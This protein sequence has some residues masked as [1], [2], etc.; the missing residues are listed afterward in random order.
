M[1]PIRSPFDTY[2]AGIWV[3]RKNAGL[4][5]GYLGL[6]AAVEILFTVTGLDAAI[7]GLGLTAIGVYTLVYLVALFLVSATLV[8]PLHASFLSD[9]RIT[10]LAAIESFGR[11]A[12][13]GW[14]LFVIGFLGL[15]PA[16]ALLVAIT[17]TGLF[18]WLPTGG[19]SGIAS[20]SGVNLYM[21]AL[22]LIYGGSSGL[23]VILF[24]P[25]IPDIV[26]GN[27]Q[28]PGP[29]SFQIGSS[30]FGRM[31]QNLMVGPGLVLVI[32]YSLWWGMVSGPEGSLPQT[33]VLGVR[34]AGLCVAAF[35]S[36]MTAA[37]LSDGY[38]RFEA[39]R[40]RR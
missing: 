11:L 13:I 21:A 3:V 24:G 2:R 35:A 37:V 20:G 26:T 22:I 36:A 30:Q 14:R 28:R 25:L 38:R 15:V 5:A 8:Y 40:A 17:A 12:R 34:L 6:M 18:A 1:L 29:S 10:G 23:S 7:L 33:V 39:E 27:D 32:Y 9:G 16:T 19:G 31:A 4:V